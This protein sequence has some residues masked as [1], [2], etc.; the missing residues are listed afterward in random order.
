MFRQRAFRPFLFSEEVTQLAHWTVNNSQYIGKSQG[1]FL[2]IILNI[3]YQFYLTV[4]K[5][6]SQSPAKN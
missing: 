3:D 1:I 5:T 6:S 2:N 4:L